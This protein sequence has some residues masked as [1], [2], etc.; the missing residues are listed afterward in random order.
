MKRGNMNEGKQYW[1]SLEQLADTPEFKKFVAAE[2]PESVEEVA[3]GVSRR[4]F[5]GLMGASIAFAGLVSCRRPVEK[6]VPYVV[7]PE[8]IIP[9]VPRYYATIMPVGLSNYGLLVENHDGRPTKIEGNPDHSSTR[10]ATNAWLQASVLELYDPDRSK[11]VRFKGAIKTWPDFIAFWRSEKT[12]LGRGKKLAVLSRSFSSPAL[13][14]AYQNFKQQFPE[15]RWFAYESV[16]DENIFRG[17]RLATGQDLRPLYH[18]E[19]AKVILS[20]EADFLLSESEN[21]AA[22]KGFSKGRKVLKAGEEMNRLYVVENHFSITG[23]MADHRLRLQTQQVGAF[24]LA[25]AHALKKR[26]L[27]L[28]IDLPANALKVDAVWLNALADDLM[29]NKGKSLIVA[30]RTQPAEVHALVL[31]L[32]KTLGNVGATVE[33]LPLQDALLP[34]KNQLADL[35]RAMNNGEVETLVTL[36]VNPAYDA[37]VDLNWQQAAGRLKTHIHCGLYFDETAQ[38]AHW[39]LPLSHYLEAWGDG[40]NADGS[41]SVAQPM[42]APLYDSKSALEVVHLLTTGLAASGYELVRAAWK[43]IL[44]GQNFEKRWK[45]VLNDG[46]LAPE[47]SDALNPTLTLKTLSEQAFQTKSTAN[48]I[49]E[50]VFRPSPTVFDGRFAN[51]G[52][53]Q[54][55]PDPVTKLTWGNGLLLSPKTA[56]ALQVGN[57]D[58]VEL[59][60]GQNKIKIP[61]WIQPGHADHSASLLLGYG[62]TAGGKIASGVGVNASVLRTL[63]GFNFVVGARLR[64]T[65]EKEEMATTQDHGSMEGRPLVREATVEEYK[66]EPHFAEKMEEH[67]PLKSLWKE[68]AYDEGYQWGMTIDLNSCSGCNACVVACQSENN[69]PIVGK[70]QVLKGREMHWIRLDRYYAGELE[71]PEM[72][73]QPMACAQCENAPCEQ[74]CP[75]QATTHDAEGLNVMTYNRCIGTRYCSNNCPFKV[76]RFNFFNYTGGLADTLKMAMNPDVTVRSRGVMEKCTYCVQRINQAKIN[77]K[78]EGRAVRDGEIKTACEQACPADAIVFGNINDP[79]SAVSKMKQVDRDYNLLSG[80]NLKTRTSYL[81]RL[82]NPNPLIEKRLQKKEMEGGLVS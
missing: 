48:E 17:I 46:Y 78:N 56:Q 45:K 1:R 68:R 24:A 38:Q 16:S 44:P 51:N 65:G 64:K 42:I 49:L 60:V 10:G 69:I 55:L 70:E 4:K 82:R 3:D 63:A 2:F 25:L 5:L 29:K 19:R 15:A 22:H 6:I 77:S 20:L 58:V 72:V 26:G 52:W 39:H 75:V 35:V 34:S 67:P 33:Y 9:G 21:I 14:K 7:A 47:K 32:N 30:G 71:D 11:Q 76:R 50:L 36:D 61:V 54:E 8:N 41:L 66:N 53:L 81:A 40:R 73:A 57:G 31:A 28:D 12:R 23:G 18:Y 43:E 59:E 62:R 37:P 79:N 74:V 80:L 27:A 13:Y